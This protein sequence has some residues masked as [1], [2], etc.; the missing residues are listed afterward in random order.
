MAAS[1]TPPF[2]HWLA[3]AQSPPW[4]HPPRRP[5]NRTRFHRSDK[6]PTSPYLRLSVPYISFATSEQGTALSLVDRT[7]VGLPCGH[8]SRKNTVFE[9]GGL[10]MFRQGP[11]ALRAFCPVYSPIVARCSSA[12]ARRTRRSTTRVCIVHI[13]GWYDCSHC[14]GW[15]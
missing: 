3:H 4:I 13:R 7:M 9:A 6:L 1:D 14:R 5:C 2:Q 8:Y 10:I 15:V 11:Q 12:T